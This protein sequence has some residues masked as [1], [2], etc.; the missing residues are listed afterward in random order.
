MTEAAAYA[1]PTVQ[2]LVGGA[3]VLHS[4]RTELLTSGGIRAGADTKSAK[5]KL[6]EAFAH[7]PDVKLDSL[8]SRL[9][10]EDASQADVSR[11]LGMPP[12][13]SHG[14]DFEAGTDLVVRPSTRLQS[15]G[16]AGQSMHKITS[17]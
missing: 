8:V 2:A 15:R 7:Q 14:E 1:L 13:P 5:K 3:T 6:Q 16:Q 17:A 4:D 9:T 12:P 11:M 10:V